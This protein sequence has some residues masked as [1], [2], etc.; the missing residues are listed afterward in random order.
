M[1]VK[2]SVPLRSIQNNFRKITITA[3]TRSGSELKLKCMFV[4][5]LVYFS[6]TYQLRSSCKVEK[7]VIKFSLIINFHG[8]CSI[9]IV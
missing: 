7:E 9:Q 8:N 6:F 3:E 4:G 5:Y 2:T 1:N